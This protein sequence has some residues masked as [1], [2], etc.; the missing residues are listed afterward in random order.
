MFTF[1]LMAHPVRFPVRAL[2]LLGP[3][4]VGKT[5][6][7]DAL[8]RSGFLG[9]TAHHLDFG[10]ELRSVASGRD[11]RYSPE[12]LD[13]V[14]GVLERGLLLE[15]ERFILAEKIIRFFLDRKGFDP[16]HVLVLNGIPRHAGQARDIASLADIRAVV[17]F[18]CSSDD[19]FCRIQGNVGGDRT[20]RTDD[21]KHRIE[22]KLRIYRERTAPLFEHF[23]QTG[24]RIYRLGISGTTTPEESCRML[25]ALAAAHPPVAFV[26]EPPER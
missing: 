20:N 18:D 22:K 19:V 16:D 6:L 17:A 8:A 23:E 10:A 4:G 24:C 9:R 13:F 3:T 5:P 7:G 25:S 2:L 26:A 15:N 21:E 1:P 14:Q 11:S 12:E